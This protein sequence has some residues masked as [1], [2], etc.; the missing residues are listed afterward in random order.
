MQPFAPPRVAMA[1]IR[2]ISFHNNAVVPVAS[3]DAA[4]VELSGLDRKQQLVLILHPEEIRGRDCGNL[5][6]GPLS[7]EYTKRLKYDRYS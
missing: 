3:I 1:A 6:N 7:S 2:L 5:S 4:A